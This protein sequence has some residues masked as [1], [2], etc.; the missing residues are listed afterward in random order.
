MERG[1][2]R[3]FTVYACL[4]AVFITSHRTQANSTSF[5][6]KGSSL[7]LPLPPPTPLL[8]CALHSTAV[9]HATGAVAP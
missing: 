9:S 3:A 1:L 2:N 6:A 5:A 4:S 7:L 8:S